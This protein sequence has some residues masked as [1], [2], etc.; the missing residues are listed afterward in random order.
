MLPRLAIVDPDLAVGLPAAVTAAT[1]LDA[2]TQLIEPYVCL[3]A[4]PLVVGLALEGLR[5]AVRALPRAFADGRDREARAG[6]ACAAM[7][8]GMALANAGL[9][10]V[11]GLA[12]AI[13]GA[14]AAP[15]G[16]V[17]A[18]LLPHGMAANVRALRRVR[19]PAVE[20]YAVVARILT[21]LEGATAED[22]AEEAG[23]LAGAMKIP[24]LRAYGIGSGDLDG[25][26]E[27]GARASSMK[28]NPVELSLAELRE[29]L[30]RA[31]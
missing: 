5:M 14:F 16:A 9:G 25:L 4:N 26:C 21:G 18:A 22:G 13:G 11:H 27:R 12:A 31:L 17:C 15:H 20:R 2:I 8:S 24:G 7:M 29:I 3:R 6:M 23:R 10:V 28:A 1:G 30:E 19:S